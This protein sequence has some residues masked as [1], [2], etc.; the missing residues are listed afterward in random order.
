MVQVVLT[1]V[2]QISGAHE[3]VSNPLQIDWGF[4]IVSANGFG[5]TL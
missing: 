1:D 5:I 3:S 2:L 4:R